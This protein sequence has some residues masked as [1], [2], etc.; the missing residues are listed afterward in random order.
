V[1]ILIFLLVVNGLV[2]CNEDFVSLDVTEF[3]QK[4]STDT[5]IR[6][7]VDLM[8]LYYPPPESTEGNQEYVVKSQLNS[9]GEYEVLLIHDGLL[10]DSVKANQFVMKA[11]KENKIWTVISLKHRWKC[12]ENRG[13]TEWGIEN[14]R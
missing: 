2:A 8:K 12:Y 13:H 5:N 11:R 10:D 6:T 7:A 3:N 1:R 4:I 9:S 14:C